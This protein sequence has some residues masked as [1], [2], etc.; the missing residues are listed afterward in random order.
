[1]W[2]SSYACRRFLRALVYLF[3]DGYFVFYCASWFFIR[4]TR[5]NGFP[6]TVLNNWLTDFVFVPLIIHTT[7]ALGFLFLRNSSPYRFP[8]SQILLVA[9]L[10]SYIFEC[11][12]PG[13][14]EYHTADPWDVVA[15]YAGAVFYYY[16]HQR[17]SLKKYAA[18]GQ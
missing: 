17:Y 18:F 10:V 9:L 4:Y 14:R 8:L 3:D 2:R 7:Q 5:W 6:V 11:L 16:V 15:Y 12:M 1:M 13:L